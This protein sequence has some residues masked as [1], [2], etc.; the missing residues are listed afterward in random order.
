MKY[1]NYFILMIVFISLLVAV[2]SACA[3]ENSTKELK[4]NQDEIAI[5]NINED[6]LESSDETD[7]AKSKGTFIDVTDA[8]IY[9]NDFRCEKGVWYWNSDDTTKT[10][11]NIGSGNILK[12]LARDAELEQTAKLRA[13]EIV[14]LF[15]HTRPD[16]TICFTAYP[17]LLALGENIAYGQ[18]TCKEVTD[19]WK[20]TNDLY[21]G[22]GHRRNMLDSGFNCVGIAG[23]KVGNT[24]YWVQA[25]G[26]KQ[27]IKYTPITLSLIKP[28][29]I[30]H[31]K[32]F[33]IKTKTKKYT[34]NL[35]SGKNPI[36]KVKVTLKVK[37]KT[38][39]SITNNKGKA[40]FK[41]KLTKKG[42]FKAFVKFLGNG[43]YSSVNKHVKLHVKK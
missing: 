28:T 39:K 42:T 40:T 1:K 18:T 14:K 9:L 15:S 37:G 17:D 26:Y 4:S 2:G 34:V 10:V 5:S 21:S 32:N 6:V 43:A 12:P 19:D 11:F 36:K 30:A 23:Y 31:N 3:S 41:L 7:L 24:I 8:Y 33:K 16:G 13:Q 20:E 25:F 35:K 22:Q 29:L 27:G 38:Y